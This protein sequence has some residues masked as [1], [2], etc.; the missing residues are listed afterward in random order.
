MNQS[1]TLLVLTATEQAE[2]AE[3]VH[4]LQNPGIAAKLTNYLGSPIEKGLAKLPDNWQDSI[5]TVTEKALT[6]ALNSALGTMDVKAKGTSA[7]NFMHKM[8]VAASGAVGGL[9]GF[10]ALAVELPIST[11]LMLRSI[12]DIARSQGEDISEPEVKLACLQVFALGGNETSDDGSE[13]GYLVTRMIMAKSISDAGN[14]VLQRGIA[15]EGAPIMVRLIALIAK[16]FG[17]QVSEKLAAQAMPILGAAGGA[18]INT[19][20]MN[21][22]QDMAKGHFIVRRLEQKYGQAFVHQEYRAIMSRL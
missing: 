17:V 15:E 22:F 19:L 21:H 7:S 13:T 5:K 10:T 4:L 3:A 14:Y 9:M 8:V 11:T 16:R 20:F 12:A 6:T 2:L 18:A 1:G